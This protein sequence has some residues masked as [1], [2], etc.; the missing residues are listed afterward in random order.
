MYRTVT[1]SGAVPTTII[2]LC[3][4]ALVGADNT[5]TDA[6]S[7]TPKVT[8]R[9]RFHAGEELR[10]E[11]SQKIQQQAVAASATKLDVT[12]VQQR[13]LFR[14]TDVDENGQASASMQFEKVRMEV[15]SND[16][17]PQVFDS[18]MKDQEIPPVFRSAARKL[19][20]NAP[21]YSLEPTGTRVKPDGYEEVPD[22]GQASFMMPLPED[23]VTVGDSWKS[24][25]NVKVRIA[26]GVKRDVR[27]LRTYKIESIADGIATIDMSTSVASQVRSRTARVQLMQA[28]PQGKILFDIDN[29]RVIRKEMIFARSVLGAMGP[30]TML[31]SSGR[32]VEK[33]LDADDSSVTQR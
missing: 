10:Y 21:T 5:A 28:T 7:E 3:L 22:D 27:L 6:T 17:P 29:G 25:I 1:G 11:T 24:Y 33:L 8:L 30:Q 32:T 16:L 18:S 12:K 13:R 2:V 14:I 19:K 20:G 4:P 31:S 9:F 23:P 26:E 15:K